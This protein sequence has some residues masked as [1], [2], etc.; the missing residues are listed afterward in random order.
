MPEAQDRD[1]GRF[2]GACFGGPE[3]GTSTSRSFPPPQSPLGL[4][5]ALQTSLGSLGDM[6]GPGI[7]GPS[8]RQLPA[9]QPL[10]SGL[11]PV[12]GSRGARGS[13]RLPRAAGPWLLGAPNCPSALVTRAGSENLVGLRDMGGGESTWQL[14]FGKEAPPGCLRNTWHLLHTLLE[15]NPFIIKATDLTQVRSRVELTGVVRGDS[16]G[17]QAGP[18]VWSGDR[19][20]LTP[21]KGVSVPKRD[22]G[23]NRLPLKPWLEPGAITAAL[24]GT[25][26][27]GCPG[28]EAW[29]LRRQQSGPH[30]PCRNRR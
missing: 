30:A 24:L 21:Q 11:R 10:P 7:L 2:F 6:A 27:C 5:T 23:G 14:S 4:K 18:P 26:T 22:Q 3:S 19:S 17:V 15:I 8:H 12:S 28:P 25:R 1:G 29:A 13:L 16:A 9:T 20:K